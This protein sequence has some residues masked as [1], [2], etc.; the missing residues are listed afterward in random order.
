MH[1]RYMQSSTMVDN[2]ATLGH[3]RF[4]RHGHMYHGA[5]MYHGGGVNHRD[6]VDDGT[7]VVDNLAAMSDGRLLGLV[8]QEV[9][10][11]SRCQA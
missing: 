11:C 10:G 1:Y 9:T 6:V 3:G 2:L 7:P 8:G 4:G 5:G